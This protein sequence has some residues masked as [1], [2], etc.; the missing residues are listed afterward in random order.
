MADFFSRRRGKRVFEK[1]TAGSAP[2]SHLLI[3][4][5]MTFRS[6]RFNEILLFLLVTLELFPDRKNKARGQCYKKVCDGLV[7][8]ARDRFTENLF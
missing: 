1:S 8:E 2:T 3:E 7:E 5:W 4:A 6:E